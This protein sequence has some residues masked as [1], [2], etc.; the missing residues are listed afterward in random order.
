MATLPQHSPSALP[1]LEEDPPAWHIWILSVREPLDDPGHAMWLQELGVH[2]SPGSG[3]SKRAE[4]GGQTS[5]GRDGTQVLSPFPAPHSPWGQATAGSR[6]VSI[7][8]AVNWQLGKQAVLSKAAMATAYNRPFC[9]GRQGLQ[10]EA[11]PPLG[12]LRDR[13]ELRARTGHLCPRTS[14]EGEP[15]QSPL[16]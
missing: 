2:M 5:N 14:Q 3:Y 12:G 10:I 16:A 4:V 15:H 11:G 6:L 13:V 9:L 1:H 7:V 8:A